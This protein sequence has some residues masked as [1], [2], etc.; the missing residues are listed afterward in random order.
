MK[1]KLQNQERILAERDDY[2]FERYLEE[3]YDNGILSVNILTN[4]STIG[5]IIIKFNTDSEND[6]TEEYIG[7]NSISFVK[8]DEEKFTLKDIPGVEFNEPKID[9]ELLR[10]YVGIIDLD[11]DLGDK[12]EVLDITLPLSC[13]WNSE[14]SLCPDINKTCT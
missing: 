2:L 12:Y 9:Y 14:S 13:K 4:Q 3:D 1:N 8:N 11:L 10:I 6:T 7:Y 5:K